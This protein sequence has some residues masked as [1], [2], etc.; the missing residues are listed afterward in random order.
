[1]Y[2]SRRLGS[3]RVCVW[4][5]LSG[6]LE[7]HTLV[8]VTGAFISRLGIRPHREPL[9]RSFRHSVHTGAL[10]FLAVTTLCLLIALALGPPPAGASDNVDNV[11]IYRTSNAALEDAEAVEAAIT[12]GTIVPTDRM[13]VGETLVVAIDSERLAERMDAG[14]GSTT[15]RFFEAL[16]GDAELRIAQVNPG[17]Q[18]DPKVALV[19][20][21]NVTVYR[22]ATTVYVLVDTGAI[23]FQYYYPPKDRYR[24]AQVW[25]DDR[26]GVG[27]GYHLDELSVTGWR[28]PAG[29]EVT[30]YTTRGEFSTF[31]RYDPL[32]PEV[33]ERSVR[34][35]VDSDESLVARVALEDGRTITGPVETGNGSGFYPVSLD[36]S[37]VEPGTDYALELV[38]DGT[39]IDRYDGTVVEVRATLTDPEIVEYREQHGGWI[40]NQTAVEVTATLSHGGAVTVRDGLDRNLG[41]RSVEPGVETRLR[42]PLRGEPAQELRILALR[43]DGAAETFYRGPSTELVVDPETGDLL[44]TT[45]AATGTPNPTTTACTPTPESTGTAS[46]PISTHPTTRTTTG[47]TPTEP[48]ATSPAPTDSQVPGFTPG[49]VLGAT[50]LLISWWMRR[51]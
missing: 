1:M 49:T 45:R 44:S 21:E 40:V 8:C 15:E 7:S 50:V 34:V 31:D 4:D 39:V 23:E 11:T 18:V 47:S 6:S 38:Y 28:D 36:L 29:P 32:P 24:P 46:P 35:T 37:C 3:D 2:L 30:M 17:R 16:D 41:I 25:N 43:E 14:S 26:F 19:G 48:P 10:T 5:V 12:N 13:L 33:V 9:I 20:P 27:F 51:T 42:I 22:A